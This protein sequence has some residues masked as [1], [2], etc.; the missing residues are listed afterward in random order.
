MYAECEI[1]ALPEKSLFRTYAFALPKDSPFVEIMNHYISKMQTKGILSRISSKY[2][3]KTQKC[4]DYNGLPLSYAN[5]GMAF[6]FLV[7]GF[8]FGLMFLAMETILKKYGFNLTFNQSIHIENCNECDFMNH[9]LLQNCVSIDRR[10]SLIQKLT[11]QLKTLA[12]EN[13]QL[14]VNKKLQL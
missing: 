14:L 11:S 4:P 12:L 8:I 1:I 5:C 6:I 13:D 10:D 2:D 7:S 9:L 3:I